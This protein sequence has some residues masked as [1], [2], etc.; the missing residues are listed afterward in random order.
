LD[1]D[2][3][4]RI[5]STKQHD[6]VRVKRSLPDR[7]Q[8]ALANHR[9]GE[10]RQ[11]DPEHVAQKLRREHG[12][13]A[14]KLDQGLVQGRRH[15]R[16]PSQLRCQARALGFL[17]EGA[18]LHVATARLRLAVATPR[19]TSRARSFV[20]APRRA[21]SAPFRNLR[22]DIAN[23]A[24]PLAARTPALTRPPRPS[25]PPLAHALALA[26]YPH[27]PLVPPLATSLK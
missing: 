4:Y 24:P 27:P 1:D 6:E 3:E 25:A 7:A 16:A 2:A 20:H 13:R 10:G 12:S 9:R 21:S 19:P 22:D 8:V 18:A 26:P 17:D 23:K 15:R 5:V 11:I 14:K